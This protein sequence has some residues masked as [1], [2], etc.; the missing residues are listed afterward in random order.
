MKEGL[1]PVSEALVFDTAQGGEEALQGPYL[2][3]REAG[4]ATVRLRN[5]LRAIGVW[6]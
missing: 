2:T 4:T 6:F 5:F 1:P 3:N